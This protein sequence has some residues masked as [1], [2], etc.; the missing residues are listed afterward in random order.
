MSRING[1]VSFGARVRPIDIYKF[2][3]SKHATIKEITK[4]IPLIKGIGSDSVEFEI[5][6]DC[7]KGENFFLKCFKKLKDGSLFKE[8]EIKEKDIS[9][10]KLLDEAGDL[11]IKI[12]NQ[13]QDFKKNEAALRK[14]NEVIN[15]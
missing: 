14:L 3:D 2:A 5:T 4:S 7:A 15:S 11:H 8:S 6:K 1:A 10:D 9:A 13:E 12:L